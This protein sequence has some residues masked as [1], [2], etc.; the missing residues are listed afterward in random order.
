MRQTL[1]TRELAHDMFRLRPSTPVHEQNALVHVEDFPGEE[2][3]LVCAE[4]D[5]R[6]GVFEDDCCEGDYI[7]D[8]ELVWGGDD[9]EFDGV[10]AGYSCVQNGAEHFEESAHV[11]RDLVELGS[12]FSAKVSYMR[13]ERIVQ[14]EVG[15]LRE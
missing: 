1:R 3:V 10:W 8:G 12:S 2:A 15:H 13:A 11:L 6:Y 5:V 7:L 4:W 9:D 14:R